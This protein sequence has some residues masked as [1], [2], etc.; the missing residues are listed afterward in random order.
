MATAQHTV[1]TYLTEK[2]ET[3]ETC[4]YDYEEFKVGEGLQQ[5]NELSSFDPV[6]FITPSDCK[7]SSADHFYSLTLSVTP[8]E[9]RQMSY[10]YRL[11]TAP[12]CTIRKKHCRSIYFET[13]DRKSTSEK[14]EDSK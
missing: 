4:E 10:M 3:R 2:K 7:L 11:A 12:S 14:G 6:E 9:E 8:F 13:D 5:V 1:V